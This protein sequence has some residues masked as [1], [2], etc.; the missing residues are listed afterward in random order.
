MVYISVSITTWVITRMSARKM[1][2]KNRN[3][4]Y[5]EGSIDTSA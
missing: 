5:H 4:R 3:N 2:R 1:G